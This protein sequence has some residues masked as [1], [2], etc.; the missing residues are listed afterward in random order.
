LGALALSLLQSTFSAVHVETTAIPET[1]MIVLENTIN[2]MQ[3]SI[4]FGVR[5]FIMQRL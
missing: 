5:N 4:A 1:M 2:E 3:I